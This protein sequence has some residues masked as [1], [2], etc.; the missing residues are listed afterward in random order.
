[1]ILKSSC[2]Y[3][4]PPTTYLFFCFLPTKLPAKKTH[5]SSP[6]ATGAFGDIGIWVVGPRRWNVTRTH[7]GWR[8]EV[9]QSVRSPLGVVFDTKRSGFILENSRWKWFFIQTWKN[10]EQEKLPLNNE[11]TTPEEEKR[12][13]TTVQPQES[14]LTKESLPWSH[15]DRLVEARGP[16]GGYQH[17]VGGVKKEYPDSAMQVLFIF[18]F[19]NRFFGYPIISFKE[20]TWRSGGQKRPC[21]GPLPFGFLRFRE[22]GALTHSQM[23]NWVESNLTG[24]FLRMC[25]QPTNFFL[26]CTS[27]W[28]L[29]VFQ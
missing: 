3:L 16:V 10:P 25:G 19:T 7:S 20:S 18:S 13:P 24:T 12:P 8:P 11:E 9:C 29:V 5:W 15:E 21:L 26:L 14:L 6:N 4:G 2:I 17:P 1:M 23:A 22:G 28:F 27:R